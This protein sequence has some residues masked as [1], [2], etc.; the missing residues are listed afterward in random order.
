MI[1]LGAGDI[2]YASRP[3]PRIPEGHVP[4]VQLPLLILVGMTGAGKTTVVRCLSESCGA[5]AVLPERRELADAIVIPAVLGEDSSVPP[6]AD[7]I[8]RLALTRRFR[9]RH[10]GGFAHVLANLTV[11]VP[12][13]VS[14]LLFDGL[15]GPEEV[16]HALEH[17][18]AARMAVLDVP[19]GVRLRRLLGRGNRFDALAATGGGRGDGE[20]L[21]GEGSGFTGEEQAAILA[22]L[23][24]GCFAARE[25]RDKIRILAEERKSY[26]M[27]EVS[28]M[29]AGQGL[30]RM[31]YI[32]D[33]ALNPDA[34]AGMIRAWWRLEPTC[35]P[36]ANRP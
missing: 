30:G 1:R 34:V 29:A 28:I 11:A 32:G 19:D 33:P 18:P 7:R 6:P 3:E 14:G 24:P 8:A 16:G 25:I 35:P 26:R 13:G 27:A 4:L 36:P 10:P 20:E 21:F 9:E 5:M 17:L 23:P 2:H 12:E 31:L 15:R 22:A